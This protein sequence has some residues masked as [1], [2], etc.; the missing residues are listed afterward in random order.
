[1]ASVDL[2]ASG[3]AVVEVFDGYASFDS[4]DSNPAPCLF[5]YCNFL[6]AFVGALPLKERSSR[7][8]DR[9]SVNSC[10]EASEYL[11]IFARYGSIFLMRLV[12]MVLLLGATMPLA[13]IQKGEAA[14]PA[15]RCYSKS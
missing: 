5:T 3:K 2:S 8:L 11:Y 15:P 14:A 6:D 9:Y 4:V 1:M 12:A 7:N 13:M 10:R